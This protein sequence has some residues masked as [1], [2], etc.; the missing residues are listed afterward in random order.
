[1]CAPRFDL[2]GKVAPAYGALLTS[3]HK[4]Q[5]RPGAHIKINDLSERLGM[6][7]TPVREALQR[8]AA[9]Q[10]IEFRQRRGYFIQPFAVSEAT[11]LLQVTMALMIFVMV[12]NA[13]ASPPSILPES[14]DGTPENNERKPPQEEAE[15]V[16]VWA[17]KQGVHAMREAGNTEMSRILAGCNART[18]VL[19]VLDLQRPGQIEEARTMVHMLHG[20]LRSGD[21]T[22]TLN[23]LKTHFIQRIQRLPAIVNLANQQAKNAPFP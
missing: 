20:C 10:M 17:E 12:T 22:G 13:P 19:R 2:S 15:K 21:R 11:M 16:A 4:N 8:L 23:I 5:W 1:M 9:E 18:H 14:L 7:V 6:S 3:L